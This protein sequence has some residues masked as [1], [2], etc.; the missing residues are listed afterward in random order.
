MQEK[1]LRVAKTD[2]TFF[3]SITTTIS[4]LL[5]PTRIGINGMLISLLL[6]IISIPAQEKICVQMEEY[7]RRRL[8]ER[9]SGFPGGYQPD[10]AGYAFWCTGAY[11][12][13]SPFPASGYPPALPDRTDR[14]AHAP[15]QGH[16]PRWRA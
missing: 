8:S 14:R 11:D 16:L 4:K 3:S 12:F 10:G 6:I 15:G 13:P 2:R 1:G 5:I 9:Q 7:F